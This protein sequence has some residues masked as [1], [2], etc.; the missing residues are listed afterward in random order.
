MRSVTIDGVR[1]IPAPAV[2]Q[3]AVAWVIFR[4]RDSAR[5]CYVDAYSVEQ[6]LEHLPGFVQVKVF[7]E[8]GGK[9]QAVEIPN[10]SK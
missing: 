3:D 6:E 4:P 7:R 1:Y 5:N 2:D 8:P 9:W 10:S